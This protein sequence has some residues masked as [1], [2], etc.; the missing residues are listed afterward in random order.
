MKFFQKIIKIPQ[1]LVN[2]VL[3]SIVYFI[4]V[5]VSFLIY[6]ITKKQL[7]DINK[8]KSYWSRYLE[9]KNYYRMY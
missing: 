1:I 2:T 6:K 7:F 5:G 3:L 4:G 8:K 9:D